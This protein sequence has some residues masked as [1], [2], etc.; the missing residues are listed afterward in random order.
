M[1][2]LAAM[3]AARSLW[4][5]PEK[6]LMAVSIVLCFVAKRFAFLAPARSG[7]PTRIRTLTL[8]SK[9]SCAAI[10]PSGN[11]HKLA[12]RNHATPPAMA[13]CLAVTKNAGAAVAAATPKAKRRTP[14]PSLAPKS[15]RFFGRVG[16]RAKVESLGE[17]KWK[18]PGEQ[19]WKEGRRAGNAFGQGLRS[20]SGRGWEGWPDASDRASFPGHR[21]LCRGDGWPARRFAGGWE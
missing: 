2:T 14:Y 17:Q 18:G 1:P 20:G 16:G 19:K 7:C 6:I 12:L 8:T 5:L 9:G 15:I 10:T 21:S 13:A 11:A 3:R 4:A